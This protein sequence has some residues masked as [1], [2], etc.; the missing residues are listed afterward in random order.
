MA[1]FKQSIKKIV[2]Y[3]QKFIDKEK[4]NKLINIVNEDWIKN[5]P[6]AFEKFNNKLFL[7]D[8]LSYSQNMQA[9]HLYEK[10]EENLTRRFSEA[11]EKG[12][13]AISSTAK[14]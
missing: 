14:N 12:A 13:N 6:V 11:S 5:N 7:T 2:Y 1:K 8:T 3:T 10:S 9:S 4:V